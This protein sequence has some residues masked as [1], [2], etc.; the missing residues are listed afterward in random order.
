MRKAVL[1]LVSLVISTIHVFAVDFSYQGIHRSY[2]IHVPE[3]YNASNPIPLVI[4]LHGGGGLASRMEDFLKLDEIADRENFIVL[5]PQGYKRQWN[6]GRNAASIPAQQLGIDDVGFINALI[7]HF[8]SIYTIDST[9]IY[10]TGVSNGGF[11]TSRLGCELGGKI[12]AIAPMISTFPKEL[13]G[14]CHPERAIPVIL[15]NG[16]D[17]PLVPYQGGFVKVG[18]KTRG[19]V[20]STR[21]T[22]EFWIKNNHCSDKPVI[23]HYDDSD[24]TD[25]CQAEMSSFYGPSYRSDVILICI[26]GGGHTIPGG[27]QYLPKKI[28]GRV[29]NDFI[30]EELIW[31]FFKEHPGEKAIP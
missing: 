24:T 3:S 4:A 18:N 19:E 25:G 23:E 13:K 15:I 2:V 16:T 10:V 27:T 11:M 14:E 8:C 30:A 7:D 20:L 21:E 6:D 17:D 28:I 29:C 1:L 12:A 5:Y 26:E 22:L 31:K 9:R